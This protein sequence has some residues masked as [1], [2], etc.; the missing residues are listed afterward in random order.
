MRVGVSARKGRAR[1]QPPEQPF[2]ETLIAAIHDVVEALAK[3]RVN[4]S[5]GGLKRAAATYA[6]RHSALREFLDTASLNY[7]EFLEAREQLVGPLTYESYFG[8]RDIAGGVSL[9]LWAPVYKSMTGI[10]EV[11]R[12]RY[13]AAKDEV[14]T[15]AHGAAWI[16]SADGA[17]VSVVEVGLADAS[18][19]ALFEAETRDSILGAHE[20]V[21]LPRLRDVY[22]GD[23]PV[24]GS[25]CSRCLAVAVC[26][27]PIPMNMFASMSDA[28]GWVRS[29]SASSLAQHKLCPAK[30]FIKSQHLPGQSEPPEAAKRGIRI[31][32]LIAAAHASDLDC[33][34]SFSK[35]ALDPG[36]DPYIEAHIDV[37]DRR[38]R[39]TVTLEQTLVGWDSKVGDVIYMKPDEL[40]LRDD[41]VL[42]LREIKTT[43]K[44]VAMDPDLAWEQ[45]ADI[46]T[47]WFAALRGGLLRHYDATN[48]EVE[49]EVL[50]PHGGIIHSMGL[51]DPGVDLRIEGWLM[52]GP[53]L[54]L[55]DDEHNAN[56]GPQCEGCDVIRWCK[57]GKSN[58]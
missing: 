2:D 4:D 28:T 7:L 39:T 48:A 40:Q 35:I 36:D 13:G 21:T 12:L 23:R 37:C 38:G 46:T 24:P 29:L 19:F 33:R 56:P 43:E 55:G 34:E 42:V 1:D 41:G 8:R 17:S 54:W 11:H 58:T 25:D 44:P 10:R 45:F 26:P 5:D 47:W 15:W 50:T 6:H 52:E 32:R 22:V 9:K 57:E 27:A 51:D 14:T 31:H 49:L 3:G 16:T 30:E 20:S 53:A 18:D